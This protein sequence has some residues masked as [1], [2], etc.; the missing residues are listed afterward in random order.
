MIQSLTSYQDYINLF[1]FYFDPNV[2]HMDKEHHFS[3]DK[4]TVKLLPYFSINQN[5]T[6]KAVK[7]NRQ[8]RTL[9]GFVVRQ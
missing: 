1:F 2:T 7:F 3:F 5:I 8:S 4:D 6:I 9:C